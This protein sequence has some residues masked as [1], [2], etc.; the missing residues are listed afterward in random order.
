[1]DYPKEI[2]H[3]STTTPIRAC[4]RP[5]TAIA[6]GVISLVTGLFALLQYF[7]YHTPGQGGFLHASMLNQQWLQHTPLVTA[8]SVCFSVIIAA[9]SGVLAFGIFRRSRFLS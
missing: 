6:Y 9:I 3:H 1:M 5:A 4:R 7:L 8:I 2:L